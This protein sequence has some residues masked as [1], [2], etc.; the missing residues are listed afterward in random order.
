MS[1]LW[2]CLIAI[3][4]L[5]MCIPQ[6]II[7]AKGK[8]AI[9]ALDEAPSPSIQSSTP[10]LVQRKLQGCPT[11]F[12]NLSLGVAPASLSHTMSRLHPNVPVLSNVSL[13]LPVREATLTV[14]G[15]GPGKSA[16]AALLLRLYFL[17]S[18][19]IHLG[20]QDITFL[21]CYWAAMHVAGVTQSCLLQCNRAQQRGD[22]S[23]CP[24]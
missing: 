7:L 1:V 8:F 23:F 5:Q 24:R 16:I 2:A 3:S 9:A 21:D 19:L 20:D 14:G 11:N 22:G 12:R 15:S 10:T 13:F 18:G 4:N 6:L 17:T